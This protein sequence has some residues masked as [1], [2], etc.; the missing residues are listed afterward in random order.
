MHD[1]PEHTRSALRHVKLKAGDDPMETIDRVRSAAAAVSQGTTLSVDANCGWTAEESLSICPVLVEAGVDWIEEPTQP[2]DWRT[3]RDLVAMGVPVMIDES[4][5]DERD[6]DLAAQLSAATHLNL[7][8]SKCGGVLRTLRLAA[9][10]AALGLGFQLGV[11]VGEVGPLWA[12][13]RALAAVLDQAVAVEAGRQ[14]D[15]FD[16]PLTAPPYDADRERYVVEVPHGAG[17]GVAPTRQ[18][19]AHSTLR[20]VWTPTHDWRAAG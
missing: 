3:L 18:L 9:H 1:L 6:I 8:I 10:A 20:A 7:R 5:V 13:G 4:V 11:Q 14:D 17:T 19:L 16:E 2:R 12:A 15:W